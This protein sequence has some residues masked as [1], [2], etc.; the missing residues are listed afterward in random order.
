MLDQID[1]DVERGIERQIRMIGVSALLKNSSVTLDEIVKLTGHTKY[2]EHWKKIS[3]QE[4]IDAYV[5]KNKLVIG[6][7]TVSEVTIEV[8]P[9][10]KK[11]AAKKA[12]RKKP[13]PKTED[14]AEP[15]DGKKKK[16]GGGGSA[17][18]PVNFRDPQAKAEY[19]AQV[20]A[21]VREANGGPVSSSELT[22][23][24]GGSSNQVRD[25]LFQMVKEKTV[26][27]TGKARATRY[28]WREKADP[29]V[30]QEFN[31]QVAEQSA[32]ASA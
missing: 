5:E 20:E 7:P 8:H 9:P 24:C 27:Y 17:E 16:G 4:V 14:A 28:F 3:L 12:P 6:E 26:V 19:V 29:K 15:K 22:S 31:E 18:R 30:I 11:K 32:E 13:E 25:I 2:G 23:A 21:I 1:Q 10:P